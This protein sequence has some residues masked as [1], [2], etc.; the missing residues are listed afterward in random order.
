VNRPAANIT[1]TDRP[2][3]SIIIPFLNE[4]EYLPR[5]LESI[6]AQSYPRERMEIIAADGGS[7]DD[8]RAV[9][10]QFSANDDRILLV[11]NPLHTA[12]AGLNIGLEH[13]RGEIILRVDAHS[14]ISHDYIEQCASIL[15]ARP[16]IGDVG[17]VLR[18][19]G[20]TCAGKAISAALQ[21]PFSMGGSPSR[22]TTQPAEMDTVYLGAYRRRDIDAIGPFRAELRANEDYEFNYRLR[23]AGLN[24]WC[25]PAIKS[26]TFT[27]ST[28][29]ALAS[30]YLRYG[31]WKARIIR[32][33]P[34]S[35]RVRHLAA[36]AFVL[37]LLGSLLMLG[38]G[39]AWEPFA[40]ITASYAAG[41]LYFSW[42]S[43]RSKGD[44]S[45]LLIPLV[46][47]IMHICWGVGFLAGVLPALVDRE[48]NR[49]RRYLR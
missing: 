28:L 14:I 38:A 24:I 20:E 36:P 47:A 7:V 27:R 12:A 18:P 4:E 41:N 39:L 10:E 2:L 13:A 22:Y 17:G 44:A 37:A 8:S 42:R 32:I 31:Y 40:V 11:D 3:V 5:C 6:Q 46:F 48:R 34:R 21:S 49:C 35:I 19:I 23:S 25:D 45:V 1:P 29:R 33:H 15:E 43:G 26:E 16:E 9:I 30:Q